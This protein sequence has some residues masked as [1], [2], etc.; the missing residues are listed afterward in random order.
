MTDNLKLLAKDWADSVRAK[1][2]VLQRQ[3]LGMALLDTKLDRFIDQHKDG[4]LGQEGEFARVLARV[5]NQL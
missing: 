3:I 5:L 2:T 4:W 1:N